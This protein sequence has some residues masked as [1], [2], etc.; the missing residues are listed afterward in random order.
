M[1]AD[2]P[3]GCRRSIAAGDAWIAVLLLL[4]ASSALANDLTVDTRS[5]KMND[6]ATIVVTLEGSFAAN[7]YVD[8]PLQNLSFV[9]EPS[10]SSEFAWINGDVTR[11]KVF[12]YRARPIAPGAARVGPIELS[13]EDG[14]VDRLNAIALV[15]EADRAAATNDAEQILRELR[16]TGRDPFFVVAE[17]EKQT[18]YEG[19]P[20]VITWVM[21]NGS[22]LQQWQVVNIPKLADFWSEELTREERAERVYVA[23]VMVQRMPIR[24]VA[25]YPLRS[26]R[27][28]VEGM[29]VEAAI[30]RGTRRGPFSMYEGAMVEAA[31]T[32]APVDLDV[33][34]IPPGA[35]VDAVGDFVLN[36]EPPLQRGNGPAVLRVSLVGRGNARAAVPPRFER[37]VDGTLQIE[38]GAV[39]IDRDAGGEMTRRWNYL[40]FPATGGP[41][42]I[43]PLTLRTFAPAKNARQEVRC[44]S[45]FLDVV[46][47]RVPEPAPTTAPDTNVRRPIPWR[48]L[49]GGAALL[50]AALLAF[51]RVRRE[52][53]VRREARAIVQD[54]TPA[55]IRARM[56][57]RV[58]I[59]VREASDRGDAWRALRSL[60]DA[61][62]R[63][64]DIAVNAEE[65]LL[66]RVRDL[67]RIARS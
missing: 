27:L 63:E 58:Q 24:R 16:A 45:A 14:Q 22:S 61:A 48:W 47:A 31:F 59:D 55:E 15:V 29:T 57:A 67:L 51:P 37:A 44:A 52:L 56:E 40:I 64:R 33:K 10:V 39:T 54:A 18:L 7:D 53:A 32:S 65:E 2:R 19:E 50:I 3:A 34:P 41:L 1:P 60:L 21:Y 9:G 17:V 42:E 38:G 5:L 25:L 43:P 62:E 28:R 66:H 46:A 11:R 35:P 49:G 8:I 23:D 20:V 6:L 26:G 12:R 30:M 4:L 36:C 13:A